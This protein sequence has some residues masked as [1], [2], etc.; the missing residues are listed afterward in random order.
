MLGGEAVVL[1]GRRGRLR[2]RGGVERTREHSCS[3]LALAST[4][5][6]L[7]ATPVS[8]PELVPA[9]PADTHDTPRPPER[10]PWST[11]AQSPT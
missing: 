2:M 3:L 8:V 1:G 10:E 9:A 11:L 6:V 5:S 4:S 7:P